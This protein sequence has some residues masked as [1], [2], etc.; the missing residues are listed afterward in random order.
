MLYIYFLFHTFFVRVLLNILCSIKSSYRIIHNTLTHASQSKLCSSDNKTCFWRSLCHFTS[1]IQEVMP[2]FFFYFMLFT[3][4]TCENFTEF[5]YTI[6][7]GIIISQC[8][9]HF[10]QQ[11]PSTLEQELSGPVNLLFLICSQRSTVSCSTSSLA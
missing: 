11:S 9:L 2:S 6:G 3:S 8:S 10:C 7:E 1:S 5:H 4:W